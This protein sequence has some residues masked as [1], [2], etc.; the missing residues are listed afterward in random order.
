M[1]SMI[2]IL[3]KWEKKNSIVEMSSWQ[4]NHKSRPENKKQEPS[5]NPKYDS[6]SKNTSI[7]SKCLRS[8]INFRPKYENNS[9]EYKIKNEEFNKIY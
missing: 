1:N 9:N 3:T 7:K 5:N 2:K 6:K 4:S 8:N